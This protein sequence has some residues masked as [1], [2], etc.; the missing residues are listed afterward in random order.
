MRNFGRCLAV[1]A[2]MTC[3]LACAGSP[4]RNHDN[5]TDVTNEPP[6][7]TADG[8]RPGNVGSTDMTGPAA[9][10]IGPAGVRVD[11]DVVTSAR[12]GFSFKMPAGLE[13]ASEVPGGLSFVL[14]EKLPPDVRRER[15]AVKFW[16]DVGPFTGAEN[17]PAPL[18]NPA[19]ARYIVFSVPDPHTRQ[20]LE[21]KFIVLGQDW[22]LGFRTP[23]SLKAAAD[24]IMATFRW[25][26]AP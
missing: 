12:R 15:A 14:Q 23:V 5:R 7:A 3:G 25:T 2:A 4:P 9:A 19:G 13:L 17:F 16:E 1:L 22:Q 6:P 10:E 21:W 20:D 8:P 24:E 18:T 11:G 26:S